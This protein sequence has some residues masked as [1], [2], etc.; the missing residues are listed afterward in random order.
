MMKRIIWGLLYA[1]VLLGL[2]II[3]GILFTFA[4]GLL[5]TLAVIEFAQ[6]MKKQNLRPQ[7]AVMLFLSL[8]VLVL[9]YITAY[10]YGVELNEPLWICERIL[11]IML[12]GIFVITL[13][14]ELLRG[15]PELGLVNAAVN[16]FGTVYIGFM[17]AYILMLRFMPGNDGLFYL[18]FTVLVT[19]CN[20]TL[21]YFTG[22]TIGK[23]KLS[24]RISP[25]KSIEGSIGGLAGGLIGS[26]ILSFIF[27]KPLILLIVLG[28]LVVVAGQLGDLIESIIKRN[29]G[30]KDSGWFLPGHGGVLD[31]F[32]SLLLTAPVVYYAIIYIV[33]HL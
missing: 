5:A 10:H 17:F 22:I 7:T 9:V 20:D 31:R 33:P 8:L 14:N 27:H 1:I 24:P 6:L 16:L 4:I 15:D 3:G 30:V 25:N 26:V 32:D 2:I 23:H 21:A 29:A 19:W 28:T 12:V 11:T 18:L 13:I